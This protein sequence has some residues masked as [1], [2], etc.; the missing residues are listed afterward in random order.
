MNDKISE[1][2][3]TI[4]NYEDNKTV[5][6][7]KNTVAQ[8]ATDDEFRL[9]AEL[10]KSTG[11]NP[12]K[13]EIWFIKTKGYT[14][15]RNEFVDGK[16]QIM[17]GINGF[18]AIANRHPQF[19]GMTIKIEEDKNGLPQKAICSVYRKDRKY[20]STATALYKEFV[21][22][23]RNGSGIWQTMPS[24][25]LAK[26]AKSLALREAFPQELNGLYTQEEMPVEYHSPLPAIATETQKQRREAS[27]LN[28]RIAIAC[29]APNGDDVM[30][31]KQALMDKELSAISDEVQNVIKKIQADSPKQF[32]YYY[33]PQAT[34]ATNEFLK[35]KGGFYNMETCC[36]RMGH[37]LPDKY[38]D[39]IITQKEFLTR[40]LDVVDAANI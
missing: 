5:E 7:L 16:V 31:I 24:I 2:S 37:K 39:K 3:P 15:N 25:M 18:L 20:P 29:D 11:L 28:R 40:G 12:F 8:G 22:P 26:C 17:T 36:W 23:S 9:F 6:L 38:D 1:L 10:C 4:I 14:N 35:N 32:Y 33:F 27:E 19:D 30:C 13:K 34:D 21:K